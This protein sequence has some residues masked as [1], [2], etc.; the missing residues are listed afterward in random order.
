MGVY[1]N[2]ISMF[3]RDCWF[4]V[5]FFFIYHDGFAFFY[6]YQSELIKRR[7]TGPDLKNLKA[8]EEI[9]FLLA[10]MVGLDGGFLRMSIRSKHTRNV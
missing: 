9:I 2:S 3:F 10:T 6:I 4:H 8:V 1:L 7:E 5:Y